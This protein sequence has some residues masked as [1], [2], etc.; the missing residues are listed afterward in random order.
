MGRDEQ[1][2]SKEELVMKKVGMIEK[3]VCN[4]CG[5]E[6]SDQESIDLAMKWAEDGYAPCPN[7]GCS[8]QLEVRGA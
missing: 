8:G 7:L 1:V 5:A 6:Y 2:S 4:E 3:V